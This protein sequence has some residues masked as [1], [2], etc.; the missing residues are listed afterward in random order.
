MILLLKLGEKAA[1]LRFDLIE[2]FDSWSFK[3]LVDISRNSVKLCA[4][5]RPLT[6]Q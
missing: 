2:P 1:S 4:Q 3:S 5:A 6:W